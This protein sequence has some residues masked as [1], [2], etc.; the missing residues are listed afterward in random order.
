M[1]THSRQVRRQITRK[2]SLPVAGFT[3]VHSQRL[4]NIVLRKL[5][6]IAAE[7]KGKTQ[8]EL[9]ELGLPTNMAEAQEEAQ[10]RAVRDLPVEPM[11]RSYVS[12]PSRNDS[13]KYRTDKPKAERNRKPAF[14]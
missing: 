3:P 12:K 5:S 2:G 6:D 4:A 14:A 8:K 13:R 7:S 10:K 1:N 11:V 9:E